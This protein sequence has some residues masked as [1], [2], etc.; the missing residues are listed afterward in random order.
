MSD[1]F[2]QALAAY[3]KSPQIKEHIGIRNKLKIVPN[4][5]LKRIRKLLANLEFKKES[6]EFWT[7]WLNDHFEF[8]EDLTSNELL[9]YLNSRLL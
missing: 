4:E 3:L 2:R 9:E 6:V 7:K 5:R 1:V 8:D